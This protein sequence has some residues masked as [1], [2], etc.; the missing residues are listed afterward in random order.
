MRIWRIK[1]VK[2]GVRSIIILMSDWDLAS[3]A[4]ATW[5]NDSSLVF[6]MILVTFP[7]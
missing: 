4:M 5:L 6:R 3:S 1:F 7:T 2:D